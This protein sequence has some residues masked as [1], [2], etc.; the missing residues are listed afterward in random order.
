M[1]YSSQ[2]VAVKVGVIIKL[3]L[4]LVAVSHLN[5]PTGNWFLFLLRLGLTVT[6]KQNQA[7]K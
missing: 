1:T 3:V 4:C 7:R 5:K 6:K 2:T